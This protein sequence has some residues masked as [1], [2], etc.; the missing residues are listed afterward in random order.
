MSSEP[1]SGQFPLKC[2]HCLKDTYTSLALLKHDRHF[3]C[4]KCHYLMTSDE[5]RDS[6][7]YLENS[8]WRLLNPKPQAPPIVY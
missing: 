5:F 4:P 2:P 8:L 3:I 7:R 1:N 6:V